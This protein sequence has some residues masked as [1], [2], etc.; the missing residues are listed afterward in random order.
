MRQSLSTV[1]VR[2][3]ALLDA[4]RRNDEPAV[5]EIGAEVRMM[6]IRYGDNSAESERLELL[7]VI[8]LE[9]YRSDS[10]RNKRDLDMYVGL[11]VHLAHPDCIGS[12]LAHTN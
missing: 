7:G 10:R 3:S 1:Q 5:N 6:C 11:L 2:A 8:A 9:L 4:Y 12:L